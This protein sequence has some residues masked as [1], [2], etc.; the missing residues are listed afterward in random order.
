MTPISYTFKKS[1]ITKAQHLEL[2]EQGIIIKQDGHVD[3]LIPYQAIQ[4]IRLCYTPVRYRE[5]NY[6]CIIKYGSTI[7]KIL[8]TSYESMTNF[9]SHA[10][11]Y[12][13]FVT[14]LIEKTK[15]I[16]SSVKINTGQTPVMFYG[17]I[18]F[19]FLMIALLFAVFTLLPVSGTTSIFIKLA[20]VGYYLFYLLKSFRVNKPKQI[21]GTV[22]PPDILPTV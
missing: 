22:L 20:L 13:P 5:N 17:S 10:D 2:A 18:I 6:S 19:V 7:T 11:T 16:N 9:S 3:V 4:S 14:Q 21:T 8:S 15:A 12:N 1:A